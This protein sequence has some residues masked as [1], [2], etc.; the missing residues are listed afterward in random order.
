MFRFLVVLLGFFCVPWVSPLDKPCLTLV[1]PTALPAGM[2]AHGWM[3]P[4]CPAAW[5]SASLPPCLFSALMAVVC[6]GGSTRLCA[7]CWHR[8]FRREGR[9]EQGAAWLW[10]CGGSI[11]HHA[12]NFGGRATVDRD[13]DLNPKWLATLTADQAGIPNC[14]GPGHP[15]IPH[16]LSGIVECRGVRWECPAFLARPQVV[17]K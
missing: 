6:H 14:H 11:P 7:R 4:R 12:L 16:L 3:G 2:T 8:G 1:E 17:G 13:Q 15:K 5:D 9:S 10:A